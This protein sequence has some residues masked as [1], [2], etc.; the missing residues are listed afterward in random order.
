[1]THITCHCGAAYEVIETEDTL[2]N[3]HDYQCVL[4]QAE[5]PWS[6]FRTP[7]FRLVKQP[8]ADRD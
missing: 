3:Q 7:Q 4:C 8:D 6:G 5:L 1:M 2:M